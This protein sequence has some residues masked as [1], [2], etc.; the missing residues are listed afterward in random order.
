MTHIRTIRLGAGVLLAA[1]IGAACAQGARPPS[2]TDPMSSTEPPSATQ[3]PT[4]V[5]LTPAPQPQRTPPPPL[6][7]WSAATRPPLPTP[8]LP[9]TLPLPIPTELTPMD[10]QSFDVPA[11]DPVVQKAIADLTGRLGIAPE[12]VTVLSVEAVTWPDSSL[13]CPQP[14]MEYLQV[15]VDGLRIR[16][17]AGGALY[18]YHSGGQGDPFLC[19]PASPIFIRPT[20]GP[21]PIQP[22]GGTNES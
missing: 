2:A 13:G 6:T 12:Q 20:G 11:S 16:L 3:P 21:F 18:E 15:M 10:P 8:A 22:P 9:E 1:L 7:P 14:G 4:A 19:Q 17:G 5:T